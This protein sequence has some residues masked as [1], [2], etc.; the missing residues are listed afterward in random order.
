M[1]NY[2]LKETRKECREKALK[3]GWSWWPLA[4]SK[5]KGFYC[6]Q[7]W[8]HLYLGRYTRI[9]AMEDPNTIC[10]VSKDGRF[11]C[12]RKKE[13]IK[14]FRLT[15]HQHQKGQEYW[16]SINSGYFSDKK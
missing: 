16:C 13:Y 4:W 2:N 11:V 1:P 15:D 12:V 9:E 5:E 7:E 3:Y 10:C 8:N 6:V 14:K